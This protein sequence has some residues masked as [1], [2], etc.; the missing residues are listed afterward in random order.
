MTPTGAAL[1][2]FGKFIF[3]TAVAAGIDAALANYASLDL[4][5]WADPLLAAGLKALA[6][7]VA[8]MKGR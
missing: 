2:T 7:L 5:T 3:W 1:R 6:T 4:P 8:T